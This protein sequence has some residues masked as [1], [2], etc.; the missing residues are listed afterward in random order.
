MGSSRPGKGGS[1]STELASRPQMNRNGRLTLVCFRLGRLARPFIWRGR[2]CLS[3]SQTVL[4]LSEKTGLIQS[5]LP[6]DVRYCC[7]RSF[8]ASRPIYCNC[9]IT[10]ILT[11]DDRSRPTFVGSK[12]SI[13]AS[14]LVS[15]HALLSAKSISVSKCASN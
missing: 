2:H 14:P 5:K 7:Y 12:V 10:S 8:I 13:R 4:S 6:N 1:K 3:L 11:T 15:R 9:S